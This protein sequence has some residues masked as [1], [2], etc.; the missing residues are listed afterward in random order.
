MPIGKI[1]IRLT[2]GP[3]Q[4]ERCS[5]QMCHSGSDDI[6]V[7]RWGV[8]LL[9]L[10]VT[11]ACVRTPHLDCRIIHFGAGKVA[12]DVMIF[13]R[14][15]RS[16]QSATVEAPSRQHPAGANMP[17]PTGLPLL[18]TFGRRAASRFLSNPSW[19]R[20][21]VLIGAALA[22]LWCIVL[23]I[24]GWQATLSKT[25]DFVTSPGMGGVAAVVAAA[26][27]AV[28]IADQILQAKQ[29]ESRQNW[30]ANYRWAAER[31]V[32]S[33]EKA[34][35][36]PYSTSIATMK[37]LQKET[38]DPLQKAACGT[39]VDLLAELSAA[40]SK[41]G[42]SDPGRF[43]ALRDYDRATDGTEAQSRV[44]KRVLFQRSFLNALEHIAVNQE[45]GYAQN[46]VLTA[47]KSKD[48]LRVEGGSS[49]VDA[50]LTQG[51]VKI[52]VKSRWWDVSPDADTLQR[53]IDVTVTRIR[54]I[55]PRA[56]IILIVRFDIP[57]AVTL[58][59]LG[60]VRVVKWA[61][62]SIAIAGLKRAVDELNG[63]RADK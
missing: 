11:N 24:Y 20:A 22:L 29:T 47:R 6:S 13:W 25:F 34:V 30:W 58:A 45:F 12:Q 1:P 55:E 63:V 19:V 49:L 16:S 42:K 35:A 54:Q 39:F 5:L 28:N 7:G 4:I 62:N 48:L 57:V 44:T 41:V 3:T 59:H 2:Q 37:N 56:A 31:A 36:V 61:D 51:G 43:Q 21:V 9:R 10:W 60:N 52:L 46:V 23:G 18:K 53:R 17:T 27:A 8:R 40:P 32:P 15:S 38:A 33:D 50:S 26:I 14:R